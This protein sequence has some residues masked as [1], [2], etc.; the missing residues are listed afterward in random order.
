MRR[1]FS[2]IDDVGDRLL[3]VGGLIAGVLLIPTTVWAE[4]SGIA[5]ALACAFML[6]VVG[7][8]SALIVRARRRDR[9]AWTNTDEL[10]PPALNPPS[11]QSFRRSLATRIGLPVAIAAIFSIPV[12]D[13]ILNGLDL[14]LLVGETVALALIMPLVVKHVRDE[15]VVTNDRVF[16]RWFRGWRSLAWSDIARVTTTHDGLVL[17][18]K[19][20]RSLAVALGVRVRL[21]FQRPSIDP[22]L[23]DAVMTRLPE[24][25][26]ISKPRRG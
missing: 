10:A 14:P 20:G 2:S 5:V 15:V 9:I 22:R 19:E 8:M 24:C 3:V 4:D 21:R 13:S 11:V 17:E 16:V 18:A 12:W 26:V 25:V 23:L 7:A 6:A 1:P